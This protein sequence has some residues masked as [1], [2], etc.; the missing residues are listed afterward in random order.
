[1]SSSKPAAVDFSFAGFALRGNE[2]R[3]GWGIALHTAGGCRL[4][5]DSLAS[6]DSPLAEQIRNNPIKARA[7]PRSVTVLAASGSSA[8]WRRST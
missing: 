4:Y 5:T 1:M 8:V 6:I 3:D 7:E 2:H